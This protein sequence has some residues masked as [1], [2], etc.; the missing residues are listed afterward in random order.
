MDC[1]IIEH[2]ELDESGPALRYRPLPLP[3]PQG[4]A[5]TEHRTLWIHHSET[6]KCTQ[7]LSAANY[8]PQE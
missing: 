6:L 7:Y 2:Y 4:M 8:F 3:R 1:E 5:P